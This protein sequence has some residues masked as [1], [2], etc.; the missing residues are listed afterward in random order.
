M[1]DLI[2]SRRRILGSALDWTVSQQ[3]RCI[4]LAPNP[5]PDTDRRPSFLFEPATGRGRTYNAIF[6][7]GYGLRL[8][9]ASGLHLNVDLDPD[10]DLDLDDSDPDGQ[11]LF[12][13]V[14]AADPREDLHTRH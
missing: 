5:A 4:T 2:P 8:E 3:R 7:L 10:L 1:P 9:K 12:V 14:G 6:A 13:Q 11:L